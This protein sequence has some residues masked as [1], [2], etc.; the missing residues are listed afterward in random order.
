M[1]MMLNHR[2]RGIIGSTRAD[3]SQATKVFE[4]LK[5]TVEAL[6]E[7]HQKELEGI[8]NKFADV[9]QT[10]KVDRINNEVTKLSDELKNINNAIAALTVGAGGDPDADPAKA[11]YNKAFN[12]WF[13]RGDS[14]VRDADLGELAVKAQMS[15]DSNPDGGFLVGEEVDKEISR[16]LGTV[17]AMRKYARVIQSG[18][19][20]Y[21]KLMNLGGTGSGWVGEREDR[22]K[23]ATPQLAQLAFKT[24][25]LYANP[26]ATQTML[27]D[28][29]FD[30]A[31]WLSEEVA[32]EFSEREGEA[33][34]KGNGQHMPR[35][36]LGYDTV[37]NDSY[38]WGKLGFVKTGA[39]AGFKAD[40][41]ADAFIDLYYAL[42]AG[43]RNDAVWLTSDAVM[44]DIRKLKD[45]DGNYLW[46]AP[47]DA[48]SLATIL[49]K[50]VDTDD[51]MDKLGA[52][53]FPV[54]F[55]NYRRG[56]LIVDRM[57]ARVL[58]DPYS[59]KPFV[60]FYTTK[61]VGGGIQNFEAIKL[62]KCAT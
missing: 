8:N 3:S 53:K 49:Q 37:A 62:M 45:A 61:R 27:D 23:T 56:Y 32:I 43:Y 46:A 40:A 36:L 31:S 57:G 47:S 12:N 59:Q 13:R 42:K 54:A 7:S 22:P 39:A 58:R 9:V 48:A 1:T 17:S 44:K 38:S 6:K 18:G 33:F 55:G 15:T 19:G 51:N 11:E 30:V 20:E 26:Y 5:K 50:P 2:A 28:A 16:V 24:M 29:Y 10:E 60:S 25:E 34:I 35:G 14:A 52:N 21:K 4:E 41:Q